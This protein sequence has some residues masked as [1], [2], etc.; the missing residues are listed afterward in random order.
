M[1]EG[2][3]Q[4]TDLIATSQTQENVHEVELNYATEEL[5]VKLKRQQLNLDE[6][7]AKLSVNKKKLKLLESKSVTKSH[8]TDFFDALWNWQPLADAAHFTDAINELIFLWMNSIE[9]G[10]DTETILAILSC[11]ELNT[12]IGFSKS[13]N[14]HLFL[15]QLVIETLQKHQTAALDY[16]LN[17]DEELKLPNASQITPHLETVINQANDQ[18]ITALLSLH[19]QTASNNFL[20]P[21]LVALNLNKL[22]LASLENIVSNN[23]VK[24]F[25]N[26][27]SQFD[28]AIT[29]LESKTQFELIIVK[30]FGA[31]EEM[32]F[33]NKQSILV[34][35]FIGSSRTTGNKESAEELYQNAKLALEQAIIKKKNH[36]V[37]SE[38]LEQAIGDQ[39]VLE[40]KVLDAFDSNNLVLYCQPVVDAAKDQC[41][42]AEL[43][44]RWS[45]K[46]GRNINP[47]FMIETLNNVGKGKHFTR[48]LI[49]SACRHVH[50]LRN[51]HGLDVYLTLNLRAEDLYDL[52]LPSLF[53]NAMS[54]W[55]LN[56]SNLILEITE[57]GIL[58][59]NDNTNNVINT[60]S[61]MGFKFALDDFG[62]GFS[63]LTRLRTLPIDLIKIDQSFVRDISNSKEDYKIVQSIS[64]LAKSLGKEILA[65]GVED[66]A[67]LALIK[68]LK[69]FKCQGYFY[70]KPMPFE[71]FVKWAKAY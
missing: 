49:N 22:L 70:A 23:D 60:L 12:R 15:N 31:F 16:L 42:G 37:Y 11:F 17:Y 71:K 9:D 39:I 50:E 21:K 18:T 51:E 59:Q 28:I 20:L 38:Q 1:T 68:K 36:I 46:F 41:V 5:A 2:L 55:K 14:F 19:F 44:L 25:F 54:L 7:Y 40:S 47:E 66:E 29:G 64:M 63:S 33:I 32:I 13:P 56:A 57:N 67:C 48:W 27:D 6:I 8:F 24:I 62:T 45:G 58:E 69:I 35:P 61:E 34:K 43:L 30:I 4:G 53:E 52:E 3:A 26:G 65:E 10:E